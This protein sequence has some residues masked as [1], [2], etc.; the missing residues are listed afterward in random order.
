[1]DNVQLTMKNV[2]NGN[3]AVLNK[4][5]QLAIEAL[6][7]G[8]E[9]QSKKKEYIIA[10]QIMRSATSVGAMVR[11][12]QHAESKADFIHKMSVALKEANETEYWIDLLKASNIV[13]VIEIENVEAKLKES[14]RML[15]SIV[16]T[17]KENLK[18]Q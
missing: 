7:F 15:T 14:L 3:N 10:K 18:K 12:A 13:T 2:M 6:K 9:L 16:K 17:A 1:M 5:F 8:R 11:E 4:T